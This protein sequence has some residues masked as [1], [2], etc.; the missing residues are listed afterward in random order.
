MTSEKTI[1][2]VFV[3]IGLFAL[4]YLSILGTL[5]LILYNTTAINQN[6]KILDIIPM[7]PLIWIIWFAVALAIAII[8]LILIWVGVSL[9]KTPSLEEIDVEE[10]EK[11]VEK[12]LAQQSG[13]ATSK[14]ENSSKE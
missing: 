4:I 1:G 10:L 7:P 5:A 12:E 9:I 8:S 11:E 6:T 13:E 2:S 3:I 14:E